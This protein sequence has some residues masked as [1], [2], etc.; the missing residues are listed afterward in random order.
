LVSLGIELAAGPGGGETALIAFDVEETHPHWAELFALF[1]KWNVSDVSWSE[2]SNEEIQAAR[3][4][5]L[6]AAWHHGYPQ[7]D[8]GSFGYLTATYDL[9]EYCSECGTGLKQKA[10]FQMKAE[11]VWGHKSVLQLNWIFDE[12]F[13]KPEVWQSVFAPFGVECRPVT[14]IA[15]AE[16]STVVQIVV[17]QQSAIVADDL[18]YKKCIKCARVKYV[19]VTRGQFPRLLHEPNAHMVKTTQYFGSGRSAFRQVIVSQEI[20]R[21]LASGKIRGY[22]VC[23]VA[24]SMADPRV[25]AD[26]LGL[27]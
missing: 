14:N 20:S 15:G 26:F 27:D 2:F 3:W 21:A 8:Q 7:P 23:P 12:Y 17:N 1:Q 25:A 18:P 9:A 4:L 16:L 13:V 6:L 19:P 24:P 10:P 22:S 11:P 5:T